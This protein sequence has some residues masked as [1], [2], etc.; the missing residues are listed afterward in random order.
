MGTIKRTVNVIQ[1]K[2][3]A[4]ANCHYSLLGALS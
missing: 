2:N 1:K 4:S 3:S